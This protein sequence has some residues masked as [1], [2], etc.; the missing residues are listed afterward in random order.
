MLLVKAFS[1]LMLKILSFLSMYLH[2]FF[3]FVSI[4]QIVSSLDVELFSFVQFLLFYSS[5]FYGAG[6]FLSFS[7][8]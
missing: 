4:S 6:T 7:L 5:V 3:P 1:V 2:V 8:Q